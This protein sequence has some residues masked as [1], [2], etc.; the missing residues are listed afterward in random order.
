MKKG[1]RKNGERKIVLVSG[2]RLSLLKTQ[3]L[4]NR[5][6]ER[7]FHPKTRWERRANLYLGE[8]SEKQV[9]RKDKTDEVH[10]SLWPKANPEKTRGERPY[11]CLNKAPA[12]A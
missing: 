12:I 1:K 11:N 4:G 2:R 10:R 8:I 7:R 3:E 6:A 9:K 5:S